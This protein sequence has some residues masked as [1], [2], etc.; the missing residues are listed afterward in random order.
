MSQLFG[1]IFHRPL[2]D[3]G[4]R[5]YRTCN[6]FCEHWTIMIIPVIHQSF[7]SLFLLVIT[8]SLWW[9]SLFTIGF[10]FLL[11]NKSEGGISSRK[12]GVS[13]P[14]KVTPEL[15]FPKLVCR[16]VNVVMGE[17]ISVECCCTIVFGVPA[18]VVGV[19]WETI[20]LGFMK[21]LDCTNTCGSF[22]P[23]SDVLISWNNTYGLFGT[24]SALCLMED[25]GSD[26][27][28]LYSYERGVSIDSP[29]NIFGRLFC[30]CLWK[31]RILACWF[32]G[33]VRNLLLTSS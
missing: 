30:L 8:P 24:F 9:D 16:G 15:G 33:R 28:Y 29:C 23:N 4:K 21:A 18:E 7:T 19:E 10:C 13:S 14:T 1:Q 27:V 20:C 22:S 31:L 26:L 32:G 17:A 6:F 2:I 12:I 25:L 3:S 11:K 5:T